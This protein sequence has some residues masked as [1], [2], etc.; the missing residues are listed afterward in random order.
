M[1]YQTLLYDPLRTSSL[2]DK[3]NIVLPHE[4]N[5]E[6]FNSKEFIQTC[7][8]MI[9]EVSFPATGLGIELGWADIYGI[10]IICVYQK[11]AKIAGSLRMVT[12][13]FVEY[14][15]NEELVSGIENLLST[16]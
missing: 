11:G 13:H 6:P 7:D 3:H 10:P 1:D 2:N 4:E 16:F 12:N 9:A 14:S 15:N 8:V 5:Q